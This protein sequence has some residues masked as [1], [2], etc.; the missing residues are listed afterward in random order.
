MST[1]AVMAERNIRSGNLE[2]PP[3][4]VMKDFHAVLYCAMLNQKH[5]VA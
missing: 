3:A 4:T 2:G 5:R 1:M